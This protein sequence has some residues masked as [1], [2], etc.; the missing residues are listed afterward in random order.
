MNIKAYGPTQFYSY[1]TY[2][3]DNDVCQILETIGFSDVKNLIIEEFFANEIGIEL[4][5]EGFHELLLIFVQNNVFDNDEILI[6]YTD[7]V[8]KIRELLNLEVNLIQDEKQNQW[9]Q[10]IN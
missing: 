10:E 6:T 1:K 3:T 2:K 7:E 9:Q 4:D 8:K 5:E